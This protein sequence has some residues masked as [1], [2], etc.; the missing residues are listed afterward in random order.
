MLLIEIVQGNDNPFT[1]STLPDTGSTK[2][3]MARDAAEKNNISFDKTYD[4]ILTDAQG[5]HMDVSGLTFI[6]IR[7]KNIDGDLNKEGEYSTIPCLIS[8][9]LKNEMFLSWRDLQRIG[10]ISRHFPEVWSNEAS[11]TENR[12]T[13]TAKDRARTTRIAP[14]ID[15][16]FEDFAEVFAEDLAGGKHMERQMDITLDEEV[17]KYKRG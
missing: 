1:F 17:T 2:A 15:A 7:P 13:M 4:G 6:S 12:A 10:S 8:S 11:W 3:I 9:T 16:I 14:E 5:R